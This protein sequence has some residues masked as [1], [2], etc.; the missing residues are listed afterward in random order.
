MANLEPPL[1]VPVGNAPLRVSLSTIL[2][3]GPVKK[4]STDHP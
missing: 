1:G 2:P 3:E 4:M